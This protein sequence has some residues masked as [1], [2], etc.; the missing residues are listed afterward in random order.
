MYVSTFLIGVDGA[1]YK[2]FV[3]YNVN[4]VVDFLNDDV[5]IYYER[6]Q[7]LLNLSLQEINLPSNLMRVQYNCECIVDKNIFCLSFLKPI[8]DNFDGHFAEN[9]NFL[10]TE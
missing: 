4:D 10:I 6:D 2:H 1:P 5:V 8:H 9:W 7:E 3:F